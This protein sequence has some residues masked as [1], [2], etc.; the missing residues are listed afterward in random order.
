MS[1]EAVTAPVPLT[2]SE[3]REYDRAGD[4]D[5]RW[6][7]CRPDREYRL[8]PAKPSEAKRFAGRLPVTH[9]LVRKVHELCRLR[10]PRALDHR[11]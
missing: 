1:A 8:R 5:R 3:Q 4:R 6:F 7:A 9:V 2:I 11:W 10:F